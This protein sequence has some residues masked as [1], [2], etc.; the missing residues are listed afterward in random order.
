MQT[1]F[2]L[3]LSLSFSLSL[4]HS[5]P[6]PLFLFLP[7]SF[8]LVS[9][10]FY[11]LYAFLL[12]A[13]Y[14]ARGELASSS[15]F[16]PL[17]TELPFLCLISRSNLH[18]NVRDFFLT[19]P[20]CSVITMLLLLRPADIL[21]ASRS[22]S[23]MSITYHI[24]FFFFFS[25]LCYYVIYYGGPIRIFILRADGLPLS[26]FSFHS[27]FLYHLHILPHFTIICEQDN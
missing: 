16:L 1:I 24:R 23:A 18:K 21:N 10:F 11:C 3:S 7:S 5:L 26:F 15:P 19:L 4:S 14:Y 6:L 9:S 20:L 13:N 22:P 12:E 27:P 25:F 8:P 17:I 2:C